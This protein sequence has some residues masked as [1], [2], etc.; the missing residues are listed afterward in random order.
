[1]DDK[2]QQFTSVLNEMTEESFGYVVMACVN[3]VKQNSWNGGF[4]PESRDSFKKLAKAVN[5]YVG[6]ELINL[7]NLD[8]AS[9][10]AGN[11]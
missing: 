11:F 9:G 10:K 2:I 3:V 7:T 5:D 4:T 8:D 6:G 1:M